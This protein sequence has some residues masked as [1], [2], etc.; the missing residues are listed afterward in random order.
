[1]IRS[2]PVAYATRLAGSNLV[3][4]QHARFSVAG[5]A[6]DETAVFSVDLNEAT[7]LTRGVTLENGFHGLHDGDGVAVG[8]EVVV[9]EGPG[10]RQTGWSLAGGPAV[11]HIGHFFEE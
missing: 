1:M 9:G 8:G 11:L 6:Q 3:G 7:G 10:L 2:Q 5:S 4:I